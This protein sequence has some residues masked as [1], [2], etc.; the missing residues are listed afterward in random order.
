MREAVC[1]HLALSFALFLL[2][3]LERLSRRVP[4]ELLISFSSGFQRERHIILGAA[5]AMLFICIFGVDGNA[6]A[7]AF[8]GR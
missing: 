8:G 2:S 4:G 3:S 6:I 5:D 1:L 7:F